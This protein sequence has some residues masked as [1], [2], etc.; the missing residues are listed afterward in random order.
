MG[1]SRRVAG[2][3]ERV[4]EI[5]V[6]QDTPRLARE[7]RVV[8]RVGEE[9]VRE[10]AARISVGAEA[11]DVAEDCR[12]A[13]GHRFD[14][15]KE[16]AFASA[17]ACPEEEVEARVEITHLLD[18]DR[19]VVLDV[20]A[21]RARG[22]FGI[23]DRR[24]ACA[25]E[26][27]LEVLGEARDR[28]Q[29]SGQVLPPDAPRADEADAQPSAGRAVSAARGSRALPLSAVRGVE[30]GVNAVG[31]DCGVGAVDRSQ[32]PG[33]E[34]RD[35][36]FLGRQSVDPFDRREPRLVLRVVAFVAL[37]EVQRRTAFAREG[38]GHGRAP[39]SD[40]DVGSTQARTV[41]VVAVDDCEVAP[42]LV[43]VRRLRSAE[44]EN[45]VPALV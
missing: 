5:G 27:D 23:A 20:E 34:A 36:E 8:T 14:R 21:G 39:S 31:H 13:A 26:R 41:E 28:S 16:K 37:A 45:L 12:D 19:D 30:A 38:R 10:R 22:A 32:A 3:D 15:R 7:G 11:L 25:H 1:T 29:A 40:G 2:F 6:G 33:E 44:D 17:E 18:R 4:A 35:D 9:R 43:P 42:K 24:W